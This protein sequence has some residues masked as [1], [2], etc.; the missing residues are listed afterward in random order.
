MNFDFWLCPISIVWNVLEQFTTRYQKHHANG[1][2][3]SERY[4]FF[5]KSKARVTKHDDQSK[6]RHPEGASLDQSCRSERFIVQKCPVRCESIGSR[7]FDEHSESEFLVSTI[8]ALR[9]NLALKC[10]AKRS[11]GFVLADCVGRLDT[12]QMTGE[13]LPQFE[14]EWVCF[15]DNQEWWDRVCV[16][17]QWVVSPTMCGVA[18]KHFRTALCTVR[19]PERVMSVGSLL[20]VLLCC[21]HVLTDF[22][23]H[24]CC[25]AQDE[26]PTF[27]ELE[28][29]HIECRHTWTPNS[30][31]T[32]TPQWRASA[33]THR[34]LT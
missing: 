12:S 14:G 2:D 13:S 24:I 1:A 19:L 28:P 11:G 6:E 8:E 17:I 27:D 23:V 25:M 15:F 34:S 9:K 3:E 7:E 31:H 18:L 10:N 30:R 29:W 5:K 22:F 33:R 20:R 4:G 16:P 26:H 21:T 32:R